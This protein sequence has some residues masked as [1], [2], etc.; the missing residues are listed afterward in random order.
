MEGA[1]EE[2]GQFL[3]TV[4]S[5][6]RPREKKVRK[7][8]W[9][10]IIED[11]TDAPP[12]QIKKK[13]GAKPELEDRDEKSKENNKT[14]GNYVLPRAKWGKEHKVLLTRTWEA[15][16]RDDYDA[17][18]ALVAREKALVHAR[19][20]D[21]RGPLFWAYEYGRQ[22]MVTLLLKAGANPTAKDASGKTAPETVAEVQK[23]IH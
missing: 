22:T 7:A 13:E 14:G 9:R 19:S 2:L 21:G 8:A 4:P 15:I 10:P 6:Q 18:S 20:E 17:L 16:Y 11:F 1:S 3:T 23:M 5:F 12:D